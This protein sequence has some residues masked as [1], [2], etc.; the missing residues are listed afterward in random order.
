[1][2]I[3]TL[4]YTAT[5]AYASLQELAL[6]SVVDRRKT[7]EGNQYHLLVNPKDNPEC[8]ASAV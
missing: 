2:Y 1:M 5:N 7:K 4:R 6:M 3:A 8:F